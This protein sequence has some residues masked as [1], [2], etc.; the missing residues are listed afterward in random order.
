MPCAD[1]SSSLALALVL[2]AASMSAPASA[3]PGSKPKTGNHRATAAARQESPASPV[4][5][6]GTTSDPLLGLPA[7]NADCER[8]VRIG[9]DLIDLSTSSAASDDAENT[10]NLGYVGDELR[11]TGD[12]QSPQ[13]R[14]S[15][16]NLQKLFTEWQ[17]H[18]GGDARLGSPNSP[19]QD[20]PRQGTDRRRQ[21]AIL[22]LS[23]DNL[24][25]IAAFF[26]LV[27]SLSAIFM[28]FL[29]RRDGSR[30]AGRLK[31][32]ESDVATEKAARDQAIEYLRHGQQQLRENLNAHAGILAKL[33]GAAQA[34]GG[35]ANWGREA[36]SLHDLK[37]KSMPDPGPA[38]DSANVPDDGDTPAADYPNP[39]PPTARAA[40]DGFVGTVA[41]LL[42]R[43][44]AGSRTMRY[45]T[46]AKLLID[47]SADFWFTVFP[48]PDTRAMRVLPSMQRAAL[49]TELY[50]F[51]ALFDVEGTGP[52]AISVIQH[53][54]LEEIG[55]AFLVQSK[56]RL[57]LG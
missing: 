8:L 48:D 40:G 33:Q 9:H 23:T 53:P 7:S 30:R 12:I 20:P 46:A 22:R 28:G 17:S 18:P 19:S 35:A 56:G 11:Q 52:A 10:A 2:V 36:P 32:V 42:R 34:G 6:D 25:L 50:G 3:G 4:C 44:P 5:W 31:A 29:N 54:R 51:E 47:G 38:H 43:A 57:R 27:V 13:G 41:D 39:L 1:R 14:K 37:Q 16:E 45:D 26:A 49:P 21:D 55:T 24:A 15:L